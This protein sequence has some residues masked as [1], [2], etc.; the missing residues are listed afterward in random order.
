MQHCTAHRKPADCLWIILSLLVVVLAGSPWL[1]RAEE[2]PSNFTLQSSIQHALKNS[3]QVLSAIE[4]VGAAEANKKKQFTEFLPKLSA[5]YA[6]RRAD[7]ETSLNGF[8]INPEDLH[9]FTATARQPIFSGFSR[10]TQYDISALGLDIAE[11]VEQETRQDLI[12]EVK[13]AY[14]EVLQKEKLEKVA[15]QATT[16]LQAQS[17]VSKNFYEVGM[18][19]KNDFLQAEVE[20]ANAQ[21]DFVVAQNNVQLARSRFNTVLRRSVDATFTIEDVLTYEVFTRTYEDCVETAME[22]RTEMKVADLEVET[23]E[24]GVKLTKSDYYPSIDLLANYYKRGEDFSLDGGEG[25]LK[26]EEWDVVA[27]AS[28]TFF[29]WGKTRYGAQEKVRRVNQ[30]RLKRA[31]VEDN[32]RQ[33]VKGAYLTVKAAETAVTTVEKAVEQAKENYRMN[34]ERYKEQVATSTD[35]LIAQTLLTRTQNNY[36]NALSA[37]NV[38]KAGLHRAMGLEVLTQP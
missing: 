20:L 16:Q 14:F 37:F 15:Q 10:L 13:T 21:Q 6:Y 1:C 12:L 31:S 34:E 35:M 32:I 9:E 18:V 8:I 3:T 38:A 23:A 27:V 22:Q 19:P 36:Y 2:P 29:E 26:E 24:K 5:E 11:L 28:W 4:G 33:Q 25:I 7:G 17:K 30:A